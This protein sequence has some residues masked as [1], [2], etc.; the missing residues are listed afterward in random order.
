MPQ[1]EAAPTDEAIKGTLATTIEIHEW[2]ERPMLFLYEL[3]DGE[4]HASSMVVLDVPP[5]EIPGA[6]VKIVARGLRDGER[7]YL[8]VLQFEGYLVSV[9]DAGDPGAQ[10]FWQQADNRQLGTRPDAEETLTVHG[11]T[12]DG[13]HCTGLKY[14]SGKPSLLDMSVLSEAEGRFVE[15]L[16]ICAVA[17]RA[18]RD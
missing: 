9:P 1:L 16:Q 4:L 14:R 15:V 10:E 8:L 2:D 7:P 11:V 12:I 5:E 6:V 3:K 13:R 17:A 18:A